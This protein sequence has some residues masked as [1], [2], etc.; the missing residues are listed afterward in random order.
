METKGQCS[1]IRWWLEP[2]SPINDSRVWIYVP[3]Y[4]IEV[5]RRPNAMSGS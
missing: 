4:F 3:F 5:G 1:G 2:S